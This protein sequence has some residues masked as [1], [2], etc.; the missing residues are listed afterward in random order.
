MRYILISLL[1]CGAT[2]SPVPAGKKLAFTRPADVLRGSAPE[3]AL[4]KG[5]VP[6]G[7]RNAI[8]VAIKTK[9]DGSVSEV[10]LKRSTKSKEIDERL[11]EVVRG[12]RFRESERGMEAA[13]TIILEIR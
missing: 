11:V 6:K 2:A 8:V 5:G 13:F 4:P 7:F 3:I 12:W 1:L 9:P 10:A